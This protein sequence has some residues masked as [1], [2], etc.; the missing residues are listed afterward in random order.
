MITYDAKALIEFEDNERRNKQTAYENYEE[1]VLELSKYMFV[2]GMY[3][4]IN[5]IERSQF[6]NI[7]RDLDDWI[8]LNTTLV[9]NEYDMYEIPIDLV[10]V[11]LKGTSSS[12]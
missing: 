4:Q 12:I 9:K 2:H 6:R 5:G 11:T 10:N 8:K 7:N 3:E 1:D